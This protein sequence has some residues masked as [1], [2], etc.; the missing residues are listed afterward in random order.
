MSP[1]RGEVREREDGEERRVKE[2]WR[3]A[4]QTPS[5]RKRLHH[6]RVLAPRRVEHR[7]FT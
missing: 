2:G 6:D 1:G 3:V 5:P 4:G 7:E